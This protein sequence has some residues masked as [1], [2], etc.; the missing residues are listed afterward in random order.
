MKAN[1]AHIYTRDRVNTAFTALWIRSF[2]KLGRFG[3]IL[4][5]SGMIFIIICEDLVA[6]KQIS[7]TC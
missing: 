5:V 7:I 2:G 3:M 4:Y 6:G 1:G